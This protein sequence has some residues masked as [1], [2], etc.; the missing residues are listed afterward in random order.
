MQ[1]RVRKYLEYILEGERYQGEK[2]V[3]D[4]LS[5]ALQND[6]L[7]E[8]NVKALQG[9]NVLS[10]S[11]TQKFLS[12]LAKDLKEST[13]SPEEII[14]KEYESEN[15]SIYFISTGKVNIYYHKCDRVLKT[16]AK[17]E[18]FGEMSFFSGL[19]RTAGAKSVNFT[20]VYSIQRERFIE[21]VQHFPQDRVILPQQ[22]RYLFHYV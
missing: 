17:G 3:L 1:V 21:A 4:L 15:K 11:F 18:Y 13:L 20:S 10:Y 12:S 19:P 9:C 2:N 5:S 7:V 8:I 6:V 16:L 22:S 14:F